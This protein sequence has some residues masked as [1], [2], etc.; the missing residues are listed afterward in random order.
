VLVAGIVCSLLGIGGGE[1]FGPFMLTMGIIPQVSSATTSAMA[2]AINNI[3]H[4][5]V[6]DTLPVVPG[7]ILFGVGMSAG[8][9][10]RVGA[11]HITKMFGR[12]SILIFILA[13]ILFISGCIMLSEL[14]TD[15]ISLEIDSACSH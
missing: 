13:G 9:V 12:P 15:P 10:G 1:L 3:V 14:V 7:L 11:L 8:V 5:V 6:L 2:S 4:N